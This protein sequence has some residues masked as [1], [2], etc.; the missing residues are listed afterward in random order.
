MNKV[1]NGCNGLEQVPTCSTWPPSWL[2]EVALPTVAPP[3]PAL[4]PR[5]VSAEVNLLEPSPDHETRV[6]DLATDWRIEWDER[7]A[8]MEYDAGLC[9]ERAEALALTEIVREMRAA[10]LALN[11]SSP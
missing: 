9:R 11:R 8:V 5:V 10:M 2:A 3:T 1:S 7:A 6:E 4:S